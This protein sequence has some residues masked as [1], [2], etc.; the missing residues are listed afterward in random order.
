MLKR[1]VWGRVHV[2]SN[3]VASSKYIIL[4]CNAMLKGSD[5]LLWI[6]PLKIRWSGNGETGTNSLATAISD[7]VSA[8]A[9]NATCSRRKID[10]MVCMNTVVRK[11]SQISSSILRNTSTLQNTP[12]PTSE[13]VNKSAALRSHL[14]VIYKNCRLHVGYNVLRTSTFRSCVFCTLFFFSNFYPPLFS[15]IDRMHQDR[16]LVVSKGRLSSV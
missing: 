3:W 12:S 11:T 14:V 9:N 5:P 16:D 13:W 10:L 6:L 2:V 1:I 4:F 7:M 15:A 8:A